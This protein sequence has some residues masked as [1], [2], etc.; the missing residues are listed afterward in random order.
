MIIVIIAGGTVTLLLGG[1]YAFVWH[2]ATHWNQSF[3]GPDE[4]DTP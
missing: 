4:E 3:A 1:A 2:L